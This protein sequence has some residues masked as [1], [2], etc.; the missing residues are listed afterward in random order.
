MASNDKLVNI[1]L[2]VPPA[3]KELIQSA[4]KREDS[5]GLGNV[6]DFIRKAIQGYITKDID[7]NADL[8]FLYNLM[9]N[10]FA[11]KS[12]LTD[13]EKKSIEKIESDLNG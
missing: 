8:A 1:S 7:N 6:S 2:K 12:E 3:F 10:K 11:L 5:L 4:A 13:I 9:V